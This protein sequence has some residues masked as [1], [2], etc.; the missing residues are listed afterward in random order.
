MESILDQLN[1]QLG[2][3]VKSGET[4]GRFTTMKVGGPAEYFVVVHTNEDLVKSI[5]VARKIGLPVTLLGGGTNT[6]I[7]D[8]GIRGLVIKNNTARISIRGARGAIKGGDSVGEV[9]V[10]VDT[11]VMMNKLVRFTVEEGL[12]GLEMHLGLPG[13]VGGA[14]YMNSKWTNPEGFVGDAVYQA[15]ILTP[16]NET[17]IVP[18]SY[19]R[20]AYDTSSIQ[21]TG[22]IVLSVVFTLVP[23]DKDSLWKRANESIAYRRSSQPQGAFSLGCTFQNISKAEAIRVGTPTYTTSAGFLI[24]HAGLKGKRI[25]N[26]QISPVHANFIINLGGALASDVV[27]LVESAR[28]EVKRKFGVILKEEIVR[29]GEF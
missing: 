14:I 27:E 2:D 5:G 22:D 20:F 1:K 28:S 4:L 24:D 15:T 17:K 9:Y 12:A 8:K 26:A 29:I 18:I 21:R 23:E 19:F 7:G 13:T 16:K 25:G 11:G 10:E 6:L 3:H